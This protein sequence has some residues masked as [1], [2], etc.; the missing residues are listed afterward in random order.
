MNRLFRELMRNAPDSS[1]ELPEKP[2]CTDSLEC[3]SCPYSAHGFICG[4]SEDN[5]LKK[6]A[7]EISNRR[8]KD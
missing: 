8:Y 2:V 1:V 6:K 7:K 5:C 3:L 4:D